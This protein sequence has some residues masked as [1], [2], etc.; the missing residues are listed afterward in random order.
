MKSYNI[1]KVIFLLLI[2]EKMTIKT[3]AEELEVSQRTVKRYIAEIMCLDFPINAIPGKNGGVYFDKKEFYKN[4]GVTVREIDYII[5]SFYASKSLV[6]LF[7][8]DYIDF[9]DVLRKIKVN[10]IIEV[11]FSK[12]FNN[13]EG[14]VN[15]SIIKRSISALKQIEF[16]YYD[17]YNNHSHRIVDP[18]KIGFKEN[19]WYMLGRC[20]LRSDIRVFKIKKM[21]RVKL[22]DESFVR[23]ETIN[24]DFTNYYTV[25]SKVV[26]KMEISKEVI[27]KVYEDFESSEIIE[28]N[29][30]LIVTSTRVNNPS[31]LTLVLSYG[32]Y[33]KVISPKEIIV[34]LLDNAN[35]VKKIYKGDSV[36]PVDGL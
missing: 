36:C 5:D 25:S 19:S 28:E 29:G 11:D 7:K 26:L 4:Y 34:Q 18:Y 10:N 24:F 9:S 33:A 22:L 12:W 23:D 8:G 13:T 15:F 16:D 3:L 27:A 35:I 17:M 6:F 20:H 30:V 21:R 14:D 32:G 2:N 1:L 31:L